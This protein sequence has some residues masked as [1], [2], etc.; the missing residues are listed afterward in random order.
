MKAAG[1][2]T[3]AETRRVK[4]EKKEP[5]GNCAL[6]GPGGLTLKVRTS[7]LFASFGL[8][9]RHIGQHKSVSLTL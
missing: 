8:L 5:H 2:Y 7:L 3:V 4:L 1:H 6:S 9:K